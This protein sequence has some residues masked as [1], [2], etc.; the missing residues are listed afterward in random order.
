MATANIFVLERIPNCG[1]VLPRKKFEGE[2]V[3]MI[4]RVS[5]SFENGFGIVGD[6]KN[7]SLTKKVPHTF[8][9]SPK[10][11]GKG[12]GAHIEAYVETN[13]SPYLDI[14]SDD[15][16]EVYYNG[17]LI[18]SAWKPQGLTHYRVKLPNE[19]GK[20]EIYWFDYCYSGG[21][22]IIPH[23]VKESSIIMRY[24]P[25]IAICGIAALFYLKRRKK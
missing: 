20:L 11:I 16:F 13:I 12:V 17:K 9:P 3:R 21:L 22:F 15:G 14:W 25:Y 1:R 6:L 23:G 8:Y 2:P 24:L 10:K 4:K 7:Y 19:P 5:F 18:Y